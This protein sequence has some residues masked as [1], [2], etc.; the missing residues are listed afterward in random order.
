MSNPDYACYVAAGVCPRCT[1]TN[2]DPEPGNTCCPTCIE[3]MTEYQR[4]NREAHILAM[5]RYRRKKR[6]ESFVA[7]LYAA[8]GS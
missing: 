4:T 6:A 2:G 8:A 3:A 5:R 7:A 1:G